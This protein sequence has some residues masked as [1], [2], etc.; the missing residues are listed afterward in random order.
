LPRKSKEQ[1]EQP[2][3]VK[4]VFASKTEIYKGEYPSGK[5]FKEYEEAIPGLGEKIFELIKSEAEYRRISGT[6]A[7]IKLTPREN[8][9]KYSA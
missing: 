7:F 5:M 2:Q 4:H 1:N 9:V 8:E 6:N 3:D